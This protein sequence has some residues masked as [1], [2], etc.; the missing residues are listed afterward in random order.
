M[1]YYPKGVSDNFG[2]SMNR[3]KRE[4]ASHVAVIALIIIH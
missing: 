2:I 4:L 3:D 1:I